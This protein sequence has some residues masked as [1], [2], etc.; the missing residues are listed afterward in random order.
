MN[1]VDL[2]IKAILLESFDMRRKTL[3]MEELVK[4]LVIG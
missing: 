3:L 1:A 2:I 4:D